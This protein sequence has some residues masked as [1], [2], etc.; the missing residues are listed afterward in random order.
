MKSTKNKLFIPYAYFV[1]IEKVTKCLSET[2]NKFLSATDLS[3][4]LNF[5]QNYIFQTTRT[6]IAINLL[7][8]LGQK[9]A[10]SDKG[11]FFSEYLQKQD[12][13]K[14][15]ELGD[16]IL[17][18]ENNKDNTNILREA[19]FKLKSNPNISDY[20]L[21]NYIANIFSLNWKTQSTY[22]KVGNSCE[23]FLKDLILLENKRI[24]N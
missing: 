12:I 21:G 14:I 4:K 16:N 24:Q 17:S 18:D 15:K 22:Q 23:T 10:L 3:K 5:S 19:C 7:I 2:G 13:E 11:C 6:M 8:N 20:D 9:Y 1:N